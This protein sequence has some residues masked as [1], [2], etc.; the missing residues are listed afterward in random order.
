FLLWAVVVGACANSDGTSTEER[1]GEEAVDFLGAWATA[2]TSGNAYEIL[3]FYAPAAVVEDR[4]GV[5]RDATPL[6]QTV[7]RGN[8]AR[9][10]REVLEVYVGGES[11]VATILWPDYTAEHGVV[12]MKLDD[13]YI[14]SETI[15]L[16]GVSL[17]TTLRSDP[18]TI[19]A[20][21]S[22][23]SSVAAAWTVGDRSQLAALYAPDAVITD[24]LTGVVTVGREEIALLADVEQE[25]WAAASIPGPSTTPGLFLDPVSY[26]TDPRRAV[27]LFEITQPDGCTFRRAVGWSMGEAGIKEE[28][29]YADVATMRGC[30]SLAFQGWWTGLGLPGPRDQVETGAVFAAEDRRIS[31]RNGTDRLEELVEWG[32]DRFAI[33]GLDE[34]R[35][36]S[37][38]FEPS[39][40][41][42]GV[43]GRV[44]EVGNVLDLVLCIDEGDLCEEAPTCQTKSLGARIGM[45]H[46]MAHAWMLDE[47]DDETRQAL[48]GLSGRVAWADDS[49]PWGDRGVEYS[50]QIIAWGLADEATPLVEL[51]SPE[52]REA[53]EA[54]HLLTATDPARG[55]ELCRP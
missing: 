10:E 50:A 35:I 12:V 30:G 20:Y 31:V 36:D 39:R 25:S 3:D 14:A 53:R 37:V 33:A 40:L 7:L 18:A 22:L 2:Y 4:T 6:I 46:E 21:E 28:H 24:E 29:R 48:L 32:L 9:F 54:F 1:W 41:C 43:S 27:A 15:Y 17:A 52:C 34:P 8:T 19:G 51:G 45:L 5:F 55:G 23:Q 26:G 13:G 49:L 16:D 42:E 47:V 38:T 11:A 44:L